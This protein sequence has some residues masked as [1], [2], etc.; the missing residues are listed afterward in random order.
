MRTGQQWIDLWSSF[1]PDGL[2]HLTPEH[3]TEIQKDAIEHCAEVIGKLPTDEDR[4]N[5]L[6]LT[7]QAWEEA[8]EAA[9]AAVRKEL[10]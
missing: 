3:I 9:E 8:V 4:C 10:P 5:Q 2:V 7:S 1:S 6:M